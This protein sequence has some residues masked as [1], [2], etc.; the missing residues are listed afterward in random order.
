MHRHKELKYQEACCL[1]IYELEFQNEISGVLWVLVLIFLYCFFISLL[2]YFSKR[3]R[4]KHKNQEEKAQILLC[5][6]INAD[7]PTKE[8][9]QEGRVRGIDTLREN[10]ISRELTFQKKQIKLSF[11]S[12]TSA[13]T[14]LKFTLYT[15]M[16]SFVFITLN[17]N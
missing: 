4:T 12:F 10:F 14:S 11:S 15:S 2:H 13:V 9:K 16:L 3:K 6:N 1:N 17:Q 5:L 7:F 8:K